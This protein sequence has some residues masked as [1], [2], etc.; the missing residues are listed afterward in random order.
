MDNSK[1]TTAL[2]VVI[3]VLLLGGGFIFVAN[4][5]QHGGLGMEM[6]SASSTQALL[7]SIETVSD[8]SGELGG[9]SSSWPGEIISFGDVQIQPSRGG[10]IVE[11]NVNIGE[12]VRKGQIIA[13]LSAPPLM[14]EL[15]S[16][17]AEQT[18]M[19]TEARVDAKAQIIFSGEK[20][21]QLAN[22]L[23]SIENNNTVSQAKGAVA[24]DKV[25]IKAS[26]EQA[27]SR[28]L[29]LFSTVDVDFTSYY[30]SVNPP[31]L[32]LKEALGHL[33]FGTHSVYLEALKKAAIEIRI[34]DSDS[35]ELVGSTYFQAAEKMVA[36]TSVGDDISSEQLME[37]RKM[38]AMDQ[39]T[40]LEAVKDYRMSKIEL[41]K[42]E[43][44][45]AM[46]KKDIEEQISM[47]DKDIAMS[48]GKAT[49]AEASYGTVAESISGTLAIVA[50]SDGTI[51]SVLKKNGDFVEPGMAIASLNNGRKEDRFV[52][53]KIPS[54][55]RLPTAGAEL[56]IARPGFP[57]EIKHVK[58]IGVGTALDGNGSYLADAKFMESVDWPVNVSVRVLP[59][60]NSSSSLFVNLNAIEWTDKG[61]TIWLV[62]SN[63]TTKKT[64]IKTGRTL[65]EKVEVYEGL[66]AGDRYVA[67]LVPGLKEGIKVKEGEVG[68]IAKMTEDPHGGGGG[69]ND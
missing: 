49:A 4:R 37:M 52:R 60:V 47:L 53:F 46:Q 32:Y 51:S 28:E 64:E 61:A 10:T 31:I 40:F 2:L 54:N 48:N 44:D 35:L 26:L 30:K 50:P 1:L 69:H 39:M 20:K 7:V 33:N 36:A 22:L 21:Q 9:L 67:K 34:V 63:S 45:F 55:L 16:M 23:S 62:S 17:L 58:L 19:L 13:R 66:M 38:V 14:P 29:Q 5:S 15:T 42:M 18:K 25:K 68:G 27:V 11:W 24:A 3:V 6:A 41:A 8:G 56:G 59:S 12:K 65:G 57:K 43:I